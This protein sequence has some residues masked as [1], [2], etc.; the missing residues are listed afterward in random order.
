MYYNII[1][2]APLLLVTGLVQIANRWHIKILSLQH[3][4]P[5]IER[6]IKEMQTIF[7]SNH[8]PSNLALTAYQVLF[9]NLK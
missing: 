2:T 4:K 1:A 9:A 7:S 6:V 8:P 3:N 5:N